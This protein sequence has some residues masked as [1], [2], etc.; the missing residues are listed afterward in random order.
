[1][2]QGDWGDYRRYILEELVRLNTAAETLFQSLHELERML[3]RADGDAKD[4]L[5]RSMEAIRKEV[6]DVSGGMQR[7]WNKMLKDIRDDI[8]MGAVNIGKLNVKSGVWGLI[9]G[10]IPAS[11]ALIY[12]L[13]KGL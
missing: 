5:Y 11:I 12:I 1:M 3:T 2:T 10:L 13:I 8:T 7:D 6:H 4:E 9:G